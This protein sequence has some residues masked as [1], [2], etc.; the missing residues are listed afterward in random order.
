MAIN[1]SGTIVGDSLGNGGDHAFIDRGGVMTDLAP[2]LASIGLTG[3]SGARGINDNGDIVGYA[4]TP[5]GY[6]HSFL[7]TVIP[8]PSTVA[9]LTLG[10]AAWLLRRRRAF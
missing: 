8:E 3:D 6:Y 4:M 10:G 7:L 9:L 1:S 5:D 2:C